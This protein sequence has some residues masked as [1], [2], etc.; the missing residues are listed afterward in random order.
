MKLKFS[1]LSR[2]RKSLISILLLHFLQ[3]KIYLCHHF[4]KKHRPPINL[5]YGKFY[6]FTILKL[7]NTP[8]Q[9]L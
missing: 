9:Q 7:S 5:Q 2:L 4:Y 3:D 6:L 1:P 8:K